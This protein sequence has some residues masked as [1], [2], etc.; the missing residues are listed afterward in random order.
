MVVAIYDGQCVICNATRMLVSRL[1]WL[2]RVEFVDL[3]QHDTVSAR[4]P[5]LEHQDVMG[6]IHV[7][8]RQRVYRGFHGTRRML[9][10]L[11]L[12]LPLWVLL[13]LPLVGDW[14][15]PRVYDFIARNRYTI[16]RVAGNDLADCDDGVC[17]PYQAGSSQRYP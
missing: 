13:H 11:P 16:N 9:R 5:S 4:F 1:D 12:M 7:F 2:K 10:E 8:D 15:G 17:K 3:H 14:L 6:A